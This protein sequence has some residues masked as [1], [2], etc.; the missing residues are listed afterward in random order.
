MNS[1][2]LSL[3][4]SLPFFLFSFLPWAISN[5]IYIYSSP[6]HP[7]P[8]LVNHPC[9]YLSTRP[10]DY[11][12]WCSVSCCG[13]HRIVQGSHPHQ[14]GQGVSCG[15]LIWRWQ[16]LLLDRLGDCLGRC[17]AF[18]FCDLGL[19]RIGLSSAVYS[20]NLDS[21][22]SSSGTSSSLAWTLGLIWN[23]LG[24]AKSFNPTIA[25][26]NHTVR[27]LRR[28]GGFWRSRAHFMTGWVL[29]P[30]GCQGFFVYPR[31]ALVALVYEVHCH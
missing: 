3:P 21:L 31:H 20:G 25:P 29:F 9:P 19:P 26:Q 16:L 27:L 17:G 24:F 13:P 30:Y 28:R 6:V 12:F 2:L 5:A 10:I 8:T 18:P 7:S 1:Q 23:G 22:H 11:S 15:Y 4:R 14:W